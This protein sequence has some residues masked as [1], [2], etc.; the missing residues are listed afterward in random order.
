[1]ADELSAVLDL[2]HEQPALFEEKVAPTPAATGV[3][4]D[5][6]RGHITVATD[7]GRGIVLCDLGSVLDV[8]SGQGGR[9]RP[10]QAKAL[11]HA[12]IGWGECVGGAS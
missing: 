3:H 9:L 5:P 4:V 8:W 7:D 10:D 12:L 11:G 1:M 6:T 2:L